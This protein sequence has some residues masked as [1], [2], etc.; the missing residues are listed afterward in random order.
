MGFCLVKLRLLYLISI[1]IGVTLCGS[2][3]YAEQQFYK[4]VDENGVTHYGEALPRADVEHVAFEF[5]EQYSTS[6]PKD[7]YYSIQNQLQR[8][9]DRRQEQRRN[10]QERIAAA[11]ANSPQP[12]IPPVEYEEP[13]YS[14]YQ[15]VFFPHLKHKKKFGPEC[16]GSRD[17]FL[18]SRFYHNPARRDQKTA[19][20]NIQRTIP[21]KKS[22]KRGLHSGLTIKVR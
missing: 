1:G 16:K 5:P 14:Y 20:T 15:P 8:M 18:P 12:P 22:S 21:A 4:W 7:D 6:N 19:R 10:K 9:L 17:C 11:N 13:R 3:I 2:N